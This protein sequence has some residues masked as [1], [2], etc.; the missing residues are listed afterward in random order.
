MRRNLRRVVAWILS[1]VTVEIFL[2]DELI[3]IFGINDIETFVYKLANMS[4]RNLIQ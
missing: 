4:V 3:L 1:K 2:F